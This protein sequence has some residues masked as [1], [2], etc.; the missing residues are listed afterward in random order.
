[1]AENRKFLSEQIITYIGN[2]RSLL[3]FI[4]KS[5]KLVKKNLVKTN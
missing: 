3:D 1:M 2:K 5:V 4:G